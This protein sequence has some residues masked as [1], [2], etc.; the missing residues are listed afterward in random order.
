MVRASFVTLPGTAALALA[1][2]AVFAGCG[3][4]MTSEPMTLDKMVR[5]VFVEA[6]GTTSCGGSAAI[7]GE[8]TI[9]TEGGCGSDS[10]PFKRAGKLTDDQLKTVRSSITRIHDTAETGD[11]G[12]PCEE[13]F[14]AFALYET[15][16]LPHFW[17]FCVGKGERVPTPFTNLFMPP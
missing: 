12:V 2:A 3:R 11:A 16:S 15:G 6:R 8:G 7:D 5:P 14:R 13:G 9:W 1:G 17:T 10:P 4:D